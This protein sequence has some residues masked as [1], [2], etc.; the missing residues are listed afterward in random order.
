MESGHK[1]ISRLLMHSERGGKRVEQKSFSKIDRQKRCNPY[2]G[3]FTEQGGWE[4]SLGNEQLGNGERG[5]SWWFAH[6][7][8]SS[9]PRIFRRPLLNLDK[10]YGLA[11][12]IFL[13]YSIYQP[14]TLPSSVP[15]PQ[16]PVQQSSA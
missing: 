16:N 4:A 12:F 1:R 6:R 8:T 14:Q 10:H 15:P 7:G 3:S 13:N 9:E 2:S 5:S 11:A